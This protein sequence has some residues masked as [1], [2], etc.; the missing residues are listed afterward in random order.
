MTWSS[1]QEQTLFDR[2]IGIVERIT[3]LGVG[4]SRGLVRFIEYS[5]IKGESPR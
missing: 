4:S 2:Q 5:E 1:S 3:E